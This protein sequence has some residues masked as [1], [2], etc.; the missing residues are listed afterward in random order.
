VSAAAGSK[1][2]SKEWDPSWNPSYLLVSSQAGRPGGMT[3]KRAEQ[4]KFAHVLPSDP[5]SSA[6]TQQHSSFFNSCCS[7]SSQSSDFC[8]LT[9][10][11]TLLA[12]YTNASKY[13]S[14]VSKSITF[15]NPS[16][17]VMRT[18]NRSST[19]SVI[20]LPLCP[21]WRRVAQDLT[22]IPSLHAEILIQP[23]PNLSLRACAL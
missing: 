3:S 4:G 12:H 6:F 22:N 11:N 8:F 7:P 9:R 21:N 20:C 19:S 16:S 5:W 13:S 10:N 14:A 23:F 1:S 2:P 15:Y 18:T 17:F